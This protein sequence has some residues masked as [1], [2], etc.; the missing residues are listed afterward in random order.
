MKKV[1]MIVKAPHFFTMEGEGVG[2]M[3]GAAMV[4]N[5]GKIL[6]FVGPEEEREYEADQVIELSHHAILPGFIDGHMHTGDAILRGLAQDTNNW[7]MYGLQPFENAVTLEDKIAGSR[8]AL[9]EAIRNGTTTLGDYWGEMDDVC[10]FIDK[11]G[12]RG[13]IT[14]RVRAAKY[15]VYKPGELYE[16]DDAMGEESL[17]ETIAL[18]DKWHNRA[19]GRIKILFGPQGVDFL[20]IDL[21]KK[22][23]KIVRERNTYMHIHVQQ[24]DRETYQIVKRYGKR[25]VE[26]MRDIEL[27]DERVI[28]VHLTDCTEEEAKM[29]ACTGASMIV[30]PGSIAIIDGI[31]CPSVAFQ[32]AGGNCAL[33]SDQAPGNNCH[34]IFNEMKNVALFNKI[35]Y[36]DPEVMPA[37]R[38]L[39]MATIEGARAVGLGD[40]IGSL[41]A[42]KEADFIAIDLDKPTMLPVFTHPMRNIVPNI[43]YSARG[44]EVSLCAVQGQVIYRDGEF[45]NVD[46]RDYFGEV[47][48]HTDAI[49]RRAKKEFDEINGTNS[50]FMREGK[51]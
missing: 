49:G 6:G 2:Y 12:A 11:V 27:L 19:G 41:E 18:Y 7:M 47:N 5:G 28:A 22:T 15:K 48:K 10:A 26:L 3:T 43:V 35:K 51:L 13:N 16:F 39:R 21:L 40:I 32:E 38:A 1:D 17:A 37:W 14:Q 31:V 9:L 46:Y 25:P 42:G 24:G 45:A 34:N 4:V 36:Q 23:Q 33:G 30:N 29:V 50:Q 8:M 44:E 20:S